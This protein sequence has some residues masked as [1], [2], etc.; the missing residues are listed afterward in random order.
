M[1]FVASLSCY[2]ESLLEDETV[3]VMDETLNLFGEVCNLRWFEKTPF[4]LFLNKRDL[5]EK[6][7]LEVPLNFCFK[8][9]GGNN[10]YESGLFHFIFLCCLLR[11]CFGYK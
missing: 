5:F 10:D 3:N 1:I 2:D 7:I 6:K 11:V 8:E 9:Y 4:I